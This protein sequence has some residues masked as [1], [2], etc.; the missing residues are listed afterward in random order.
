MSSVG[1]TL[2][3]G[4]CWEGLTRARMRMSSVGPTLQA[5]KMS[6]VGPTLQAGKM[7]SVDPTRSSIGPACSVG[8]SRNL[9]LP[10]LGRPGLRSVQIFR[11]VLVSHL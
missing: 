3:A 4:T 9:G 6:S 5:G 10:Q 1:P 11:L 7:S 8:P 2:Q